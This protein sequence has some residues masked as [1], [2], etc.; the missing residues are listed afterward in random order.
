MSKKDAGTSGNGSTKIA[1]QLT[2]INRRLQTVENLI[3]DLLPGLEKI[4]KEIN[5]T[6]NDLRQKFEKPETLEL[7]K[8]VGDN[9][10]VFIELL[11]VTKAVRGLAAD[12]QHMPQN[13][14]KELTNTINE[15]R[16]KYEKDETL[17]LIKKVGDNIPLFIELLDVTKA[18]KGLAD[19]LQHMP[20]HVTK[21][22]TD[23]INE[24]RIKYEKD[25]TLELIKKAGDNI[26][27]F[28]EMLDMMKVVKGLV[29]DLSHTPQNITNE[30]T[31]TIN[32]LRIRYEKEETLTLIKKF[33]DIIPTT[34][35]LLD[36]FTAAKGL[37][38]DV[39]PA[40]DK[41]VKELTPTINM[42][43][44]NFEKD[45]LLELLRKTGASIETFNK[46]MDFLIRFEKSGDLDATLETASAKETEYLMRGMEKCAVRTM[47]ELMEKPLKPGFRTI[48]SAMR[49]P[50][51]QKGF[52]L[53]TTFARNMP[54][55]MLETIEESAETIK[56]EET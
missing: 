6:L 30:L 42:F 33:A 49:D 32:D 7:I 19:D 18:V 39:L 20:Q 5:D 24:L 23:T 48:F 26:P 8:K 1:A 37:F 41:I 40:T 55:C 54:Q 47:R 56:P 38:D 34:I 9:I 25:E 21:E 51:V 17:E 16:I 29:T 14:T 27:L 50:E 45:A 15:L 3:N 43:R 28:I 13:V 2:D 44:E 53:M 22:L 35:E 12:L 52:V 36:V 46:I 10:P 4:P 11:D 31:E